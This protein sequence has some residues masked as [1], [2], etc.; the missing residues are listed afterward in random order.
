M[1]KIYDYTLIHDKLLLKAQK[2][3]VSLKMSYA[4]SK[5]GEWRN[6]Y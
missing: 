3:N 5:L 4:L 6:R 1:A 2:V